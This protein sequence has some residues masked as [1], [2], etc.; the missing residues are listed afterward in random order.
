MQFKVETV[1]TR[2]AS[3]SNLKSVSTKFS[4]S[5]RSSKSTALNAQVRLKT[6]QLK[7]EH[8]KDRIEEQKAT[9]ALE[10]VMQ[11]QMQEHKMQIKQREA[12]RKLEHAKLECDILSESDSLSVNSLPIFSSNK[13]SKCYVVKLEKRVFDLFVFSLNV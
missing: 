7:A 1:S 2:Y 13:D 10:H 6:A 3:Q 11:K 5:S 12:R 8:L 9:L 4:C